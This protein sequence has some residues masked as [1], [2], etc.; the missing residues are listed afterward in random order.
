MPCNGRY[1]ELE[2]INNCSY[3][4]LTAFCP[5]INRVGSI[6][7]SSELGKGTTFSVNLPLARERDGAKKSE[8]E[9][10]IEQKKR[11]KAMIRSKS[12]QGVSVLLV[13]DNIVNQKVG[14]K[15]LKSMGCNVKVAANG[16]EC[17]KA[18]EQ[19]CFDIVLMDCQMPVMDGFQTTL[20]IRELEKAMG[21]KGDA[22]AADGGTHFLRFQAMKRV[23]I[24]AVTASATLEYRE[25]C[26]ECGMDDF[27]QKPFCKTSLVKIFQKWTSCLKCNK[28]NAIERK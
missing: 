18:L 10:C 27:M 5:S 26:L 17:L 28:M 14:T 2:V 8:V 23:P 19:E 3:H 11:I 24:I 20:R 13:E 15:M 21:V 4:I 12:V 9:E 1:I 22:A 25:R 16:I 7:C 6:S